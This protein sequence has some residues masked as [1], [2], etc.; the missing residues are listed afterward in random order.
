[1]DNWP[2]DPHV[3]QELVDVVGAWKRLHAST[4]RPFLYYAKAMDYITVYDGRNPKAPIRHRFDWPEAGIIEACNETAKSEEQ[5]RAILTDRRERS[6][7]A[8][9]VT[10]A[11]AFLT[12]RRILYEERGRYFTLAIPENPYL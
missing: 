6:C 12:A 3:Y 2:V 10:D 8:S 7:S 11:V 9:Q 5:L 1:L 4:D